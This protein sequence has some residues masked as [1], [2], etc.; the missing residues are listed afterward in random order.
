M[1]TKG[2]L[3]I[4]GDFNNPNIAKF[5]NLESF[6]LAQHVQDSTHS[7][8]HTLDLVITKS[9]EIPTSE[10]SVTEPLI[11]DH[12]CISF[13]LDTIKPTFPCKKNHIQE[14]GRYQP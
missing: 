3:V 7:S 10:L 4:E 5:W 14:V 11:S 1:L 6:G 13:N 12:H 8:G 2:K 9:H